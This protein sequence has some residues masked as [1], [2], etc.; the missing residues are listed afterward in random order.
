MTS[1]AG[2]PARDRE[3]ILARL[4]ELVELDHVMREPGTL[5][6]PQHDQDDAEKPAP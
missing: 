3:R 1:L 5:A 2:V 4:R 6:A